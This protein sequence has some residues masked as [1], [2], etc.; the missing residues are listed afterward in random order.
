MKTYS[1]VAFNLRF[2]L[3]TALLVLVT[4]FLTLFV[5]AAD[6]A[7]MT[8]KNEQDDILVVK[9]NLEFVYDNGKS[10]PQD[11]KAAAESYRL[12]ADAGNCVAQYKLGVLYH[13]GDGVPLDYVA[14]AKWLQL[15][16]EQGYSLAQFNLGCMYYNGKG[17]TQDYE[18]AA[19]W[20]RLS[21]EQGNGLAQFNLG[22]MYANGKGVPQNYIR[23]YKWFSLAISDD[24]ISDARESIAKKMTSS[25]IE[26][27]E[28][29]VSEWYSQVNIP[30]AEE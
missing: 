16:A 24:E 17:V 22:L 2:R 1:T 15:S 23:A 6:F 5:A 20:Y 27:A 10:V 19:K 28:K 9:A 7:T 26:K 13:N 3:I 11:Y 25:Q 21:A 8:Q 4:S 29:L 12:S 18:A 14:A 30:I